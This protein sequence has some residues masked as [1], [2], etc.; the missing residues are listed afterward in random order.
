MLLKDFYTIT[1][2]EEESNIVTARISIN[3]AHEIFKG[4]FPGN[5]I[6]PGVTMVQIVKELLGQKQGKTLFLQKAVNVKFMNILNP[7]T[8]PDVTVKITVK[9]IEGEVTTAYS[10]ITKEDKTYFKFSG[11]FR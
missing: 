2:F 1:Q 10:T 6:V 11:Q 5:P 9:S 7:D 3:P 4:H 8:D